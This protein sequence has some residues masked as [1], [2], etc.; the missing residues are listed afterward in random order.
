MSGLRK[1]LRLRTTSLVAAGAAT[2]FLLT[3]AASSQADPAPK[4]EP[5]AVAADELNTDYLINDVLPG[6]S[7][8]GRGVS[9]QWITPSGRNPYKEWDWI[10]IKKGG[11]DGKRVT[12]EW[13]CPKND[14]D[15][16]GSTLVAMTP[17]R[18]QKY[19]AVYWSNGGRVT[20]GTRRATFEFWA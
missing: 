14:C 2:V 17:Q 3:T 19:T 11:A 18:G 1:S 9:V 15:A 20:N 6:Q 8:G 13:A 4:Q 5:A 7:G 10:E 16:V 12:W